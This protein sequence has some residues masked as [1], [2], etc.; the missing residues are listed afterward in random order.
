MTLK[1]GMAPHCQWQALIPLLK[2]FG[3]RNTQG[4]VLET[5][6]QDAGALSEG[7]SV[8]LYTRPD[9]AIAQAMEEGLAPGDTLQAWRTAVK[10]MLA[11]YKRNR[12]TS[13]ML[14]VSRV[15]HNPDASIVVLKEH[16]GLVA[17]SPSITLEQPKSASRVN[18]ERAARIVSQ[19]EELKALL[20]E[21]DACTLPIDD[22]A[23]H[24]P[25]LYVLELY[26]ELQA[27]APEYA[28]R[29]M[30]EC[31]RLLKA[32]TGLE[33]ALERERQKHAQTKRALDDA[34]EDTELVLHQLLQA[35]EE[36]ER[37]YSNQR[38]SSNERTVS[39]NGSQTA[40][41]T[42]SIPMVP[43]R[44]GAFWKLTSSMRAL[45]R[46]LSLVKK[47]EIKKRV[48]LLNQSE[49]FD[50]KWYLQMYPD[51][52][53]SKLDPAEHY[54]LYGASEQ[55]DP[56]SR[57]STSKYLRANSDVAESGMNPL[58]HYLSFGKN[59]GRKAVP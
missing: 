12:A 46:S 58:V 11:F 31:E 54:L 1:A 37:C 49:F 59:E 25:R 14:D 15:L 48:A 8:F 38:M 19:D 3:W 27:D 41:K 42:T 57:F 5:W 55:R 39:G 50:A 29:R 34:R 51:V 28:Q 20:L 26:R 9:V 13:V 10:H 18:L 47:V 32:L 6:Y 56:S 43:V 45:V 23:Y 24:S 4:D 17:A 53:N 52:A 2:N 30:K 16:M 33:N 44:R 36:L 22:P 7:T 35:H 21:L 40:N